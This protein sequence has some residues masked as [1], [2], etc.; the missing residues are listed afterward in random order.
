MIRSINYLVTDPMSTKS[1]PSHLRPSPPSEWLAELRKRFPE[2]DPP[3]VAGVLRLINVG[4][5]IAGAF[6]PSFGRLDLTEARFTTVL[7]IYRLE[8][9][10]GQA[11]PSEL[12][13]LA[14]IGRAAMSQL[15][16][17]LADAG[18]IDRQTDPA[19]RRRVVVRLTAKSRRRLEQFLPRH[20]ERIRQVLGKLTKAER[21][22]LLALLDK[23]SDGLAT[24]D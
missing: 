2:V 1:E 17:G 8:I 6:G 5:E 16:D 9:E 10:Q 11:A 18:W 12:A 20:Y 13:D 7:L 15:L 14:G 3:S 23:V 21:A 24:L 22:S 4:R 19:D